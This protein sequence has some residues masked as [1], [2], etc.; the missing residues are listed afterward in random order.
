[1]NFVRLIKIF[2]EV[3]G[4]QDDSVC[5]YK[6]NGWSTLIQNGKPVTHIHMPE[7]QWHP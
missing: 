6:G 7:K 3:Y 1:M 4:I 2:S 5:W